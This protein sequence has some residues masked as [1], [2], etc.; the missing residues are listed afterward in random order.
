MIIEFFFPLPLSRL[1][2]KRF[3]SFPAISTA[4]A[5][6]CFW[7]LISILAFIEITYKHRFGSLTKLQKEVSCTSPV[8]SHLHPTATGAKATK[9]WLP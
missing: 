8:R 2:F 6:A 7:E 3:F 5:L 4:I 1:V 9:D